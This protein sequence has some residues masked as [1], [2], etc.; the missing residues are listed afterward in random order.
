MRGGAP[1][2]LSADEIV[3]I[4]DEADQVIGVALRSHMRRHRLRHRAVY[5]LVFDRHDRLLIHQR[6]FT[7]DI[8]P[9]LWD[10]AF[11]GVLG[12]GESYLDG[13]RRELLEEA[14]LDDP[15]EELFPITHDDESSS[16]VGH[17][18][19]C[20]TEKAPRLQDTEVAR[21]EWLD[22]ESCQTRTRVDRF[23]PDGLLVL[24]RYLESNP[25]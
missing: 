12:A 22:R 14:G 15:I 23:C 4:V 21:A 3:D 20:R 8:Y 9:G 25:A 11:G 17:V 2:A 19:R 5:I 6:T 16:V 10:V 18:Y 1:T 13:A 24:Q 7:K